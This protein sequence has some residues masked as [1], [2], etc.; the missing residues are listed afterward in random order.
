MACVLAKQLNQRKCI[1]KIINQS[2]P[3]DL[4]S[5]VYP[6]DVCSELAKDCNEDFNNE[7]KIMM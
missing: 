1:V 3:T 4:V 7:L 6:S 5:R 2:E